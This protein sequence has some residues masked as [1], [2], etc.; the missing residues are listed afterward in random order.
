[1][2]RYSLPIYLFILLWIPV[3]GYG[4]SEVRFVYDGDTVLLEDGKRIRYLGIDTPEMGTEE[5]EPGFLA[6]AAR[7]FNRK[8]VL[9]ASIRLEFDRQRKDRHGR[10]L[11]YV[12]LPD[13]RM[14]NAE[15]LRHGLAR[16]RAFPPNL[17]HLDRLI[18]AQREAM[19]RLAGIWGRE[20]GSGEGPYL[21]S[22]RSYR[23]HRPGCR[24]AKRIHEDNEIRFETKRRA[25]WEGYSPCSGCL[26]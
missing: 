10:W 7:A 17:E 9:G 1:M 6:E 15:L 3:L 18:E 21:G 16:V 23:F 11:A 8:A 20:A 26:P 24:Y 4:G 5:E 2:K 13:G 14:L 19:T 12:Y 25:F 22:R